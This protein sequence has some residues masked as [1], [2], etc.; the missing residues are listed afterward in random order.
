MGVNKEEFNMQ[1]FSLEAAEKYFAAESEWIDKMF[2][3]NWPSIYS[4][5]AQMINRKMKAG[6]RPNLIERA[7]VIVFAKMS[8]LTIARNKHYGY[9]N[10]GKGFR[11]GHGKVTLDA[12]T[13]TLLRGGKEVAKQ[14]F[15]LSA[16]IK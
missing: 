10:A 8:K 12:V 14:R 16:I 2:S 7:L 4:N 6:K 13:V 5:F 9:L 15:E 3:K 11:P 1:D